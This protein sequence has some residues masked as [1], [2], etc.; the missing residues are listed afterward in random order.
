MDTIKRLKRVELAFDA[1]RLVGAQATFDE[2]VEIDGRFQSFGERTAGLDFGGN[3]EYAGQLA[4]VLGQ[5]LTDALAANQLLS[6]ECA[7][8]TAELEALADKP[9]R[10]KAKGKAKGSAA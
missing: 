9:P 4:D 6:T 1:G 5:A 2:G 8:L 7:R 10:G 3:P